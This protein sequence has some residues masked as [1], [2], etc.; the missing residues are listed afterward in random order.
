[1]DLTNTHKQTSHAKQ[2]EQWT[3]ITIVV[4][5]LRSA[6]NVHNTS[7]SAIAERPHCRVG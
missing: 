5:V 6:A 4:N 3:R 7:I 1:M 2:C